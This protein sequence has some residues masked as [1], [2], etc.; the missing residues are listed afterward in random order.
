M[1]QRTALL[2]AAALTAFLLVTGGALAARVL[3][4]S[5]TEATAEVL[6]MEPTAQRA[7]EREAQYQQALA[8]AN[9]RLEQANAQIA[10][11]NAR[12]SQTPAQVEPAAAD[13][14]VTSAQAG[15]TALAYRGG[16]EVREI[17]L[18]EEDGTLAYEVKFADG[19]KV[20]VDTASR[21]V[22]YAELGGDYDDHEDEHDD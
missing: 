20:Y 14:A 16:G 17:E 3:P 2:V 5:T 9:A 19:G 1:K 22:V 18:E 21:Q 6:S 15:E 10:A 13:G 4:A 12:L 11:A 8:D 7:S